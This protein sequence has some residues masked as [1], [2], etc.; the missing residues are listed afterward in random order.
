M[1]G[2]GSDLTARVLHEAF[3]RLAERL[4]RRGVRGEVYRFGGAA[5]VLDF[6]ARDAT[7]DADAVFAPH[8]P[9]REEARV[10]AQEL[11]LPGWWLNDQASAYLP[12][13]EDPGR[14]VWAAWPSLVVRTAS[15]E[16]LLAM[17]VH[18]GR[19]GDLGD[20]RILADHLGIDSA[21]AAV[22]VC[23]E[24]LPGRPLDQRRRDALASLFPP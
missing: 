3:R 18:A 9:V 21:E 20:V 8:G 6:R 22:R 15:A 14:R 17:K 23:E 13:G 19:A 12:G 4:R 10:V 1:A 11:G 2:G 24:V 7:A 16:W 5:M